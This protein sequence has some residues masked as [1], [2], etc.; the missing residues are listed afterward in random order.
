M[1]SCILEREY[2][3]V[4]EDYPSLAIGSSSSALYLPVPSSVMLSSDAIVLHC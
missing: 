2:D 4:L 1:S 3:A